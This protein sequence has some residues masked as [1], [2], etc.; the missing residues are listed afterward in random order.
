MCREERGQRDI[1]R[2][3]GMHTEGDC[4]DLPFSLKCCVLG[5]EGRCLVHSSASGL[6]FETFL[7]EGL[8]VAA[9]RF[10]AVPTVFTDALMDDDPLFGGTGG[11]EDEWRR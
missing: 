1:C 10:S 6:S 4:L 7:L 5:T 8:G 2:L 11:F 3:L 9:G